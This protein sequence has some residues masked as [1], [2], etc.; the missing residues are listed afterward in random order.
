MKSYNMDT[1]IDLVSSVLSDNNIQNFAGPF[2]LCLLIQ[3]DMC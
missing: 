3:A 2:I 1:E